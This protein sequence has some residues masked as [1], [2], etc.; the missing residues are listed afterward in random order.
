MVR[1]CY[2][3]RMTPISDLIR[4]LPTPI[5][6]HTF[7]YLR[8]SSFVSLPNP[9]IIYHSTKTFS[10]HRMSQQ[11]P[12]T[13]FFMPELLGPILLS[14]HAHP[15]DLCSGL[16][17]LEQRYQVL[18]KIQ[19]G[20]FFLPLPESET[21]HQ[22]CCFPCHRIRVALPDP[23][24]ELGNISRGWAYC[25]S[26]QSVEFKSRVAIHGPYIAEILNGVGGCRC[27][28]DSER[29]VRRAPDYKE[30]LKRNKTRNF[31]ISQTTQVQL[32]QS[33]KPCYHDT[34]PA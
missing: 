32:E 8:I 6:L 12:S 29:S 22:H 16:S 34:A 17:F 21:Q 11:Q 9:Q 20:S 19:N 31:F 23:L 4:S 10:C 26:S 18:E 7:I 25:R 1:R 13:L 30:A 24:R 28:E 27:R 14:R 3:D 33:I 2:F 5:H 15:T